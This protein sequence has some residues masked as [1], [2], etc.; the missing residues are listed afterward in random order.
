M[1][2]FKKLQSPLALAFQGFLA[3]AILFF[4]LHPL[5]PGDQPPPPPTGESVLAGIEA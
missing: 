1:N 2:L 3:G 4:T 5:A